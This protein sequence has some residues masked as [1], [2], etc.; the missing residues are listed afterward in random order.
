MLLA[1]YGAGVTTAFVLLVLLALYALVSLAFVLLVVGVVPSASE[2]SLAFVLLVLV[3]LC[4]APVL[5]AFVLGAGCR[6]AGV[7][8]VVLA[9]NY[10]LAFVLPTLLKCCTQF[11]GVAVFVFAVLLVLYLAL[12]VTGVCFAGTLLALARGAAIVTESVLFLPVLLVL[13]L[14]LVSLAFV[15]RCCWRCWVGVCSWLYLLFRR[16]RHRMSSFLVFLFLLSSFGVSFSY[17]LS[18]FC[19]PCRLSV[20]LSPYLL[21]EI[22]SVVFRNS[23]MSS[24]VFHFHPLFAFRNSVSPCRL[25]CFFLFVFFRKFCHRPHASF[26]VSFSFIFFP[27]LLSPCLLLVFSFSLLVF[28]TSVTPVKSLSGVSFSL[29]SFGVCFLFILFGVSAFPVIPTCF[30][31]MSALALNSSYF[32]LT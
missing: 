14:A 19:L 18:E 29:S 28:Q 11:A 26:G 7:V 22:L 20:F 10:S 3:V 23:V 13:Y 25:W 8:G 32:L 2:L 5:L 31:I 9:L 30:S 17:L 6:G 1:L 12:S 15:C 24:L 16:F 27:E 4:L 21:S